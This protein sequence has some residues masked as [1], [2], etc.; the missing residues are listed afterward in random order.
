MPPK[1]IGISPFLAEGAGG[2]F[3]SVHQSYCDAARKLGFDVIYLGAAT[4]TSKTWFA[5]IIKYK[6]QNLIDFI[7]CR[8]QIN[9]L[10]KLKRYRESVGSTGDLMFVFEGN[11]NLLLIVSL[12]CIKNNIKCHVNLIRSDLLIKCYSNKYFALD[13]IFLKFLIKYTKG[14]VFTSTLSQTLN[15]ILDS[16]KIQIDFAIDTFSGINSKHIKTKVSS[17]YILI[18]APY[19]ADLKDL[20]IK[21][22][23]IRKHKSKYVVSTYVSNLENYKFDPDRVTILNK[24]LSDPEYLKLI[25]QSKHVVMYYVNEFHKYGSGSRIYDCIS[26][27]KKICIPLNT[28]IAKQIK[29]VGKY[30]IFDPRNQSHIQKI[31]N[32]PSFIGKFKL[33]NIPSAELAIQNIIKK[34]EV[35]KINR[36]EKLKLLSILKITFVLLIFLSFLGDTINTFKLLLK[37]IY[38]LVK[39]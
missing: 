33:Y 14:Q 31:L 38:K 13:R 11:L 4:H 30:F 28:E 16:K 8:A 6:P 36:W 26:L 1:F 7:D 27:K 34:N 37:K 22:N 20:Q 15:K 17:N 3:Y 29:N 21:L 10:S 18:N 12:F 9:L 25:S 39:I 2:H 19:P 35:R 24:H 5:P 23:S 32:K